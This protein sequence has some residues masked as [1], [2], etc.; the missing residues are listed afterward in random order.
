MRG[1]DHD[2][3]ASRM[4][5]A[6]RIYYNFGR[7]HSAP[8]GQTP[9]EKAAIDLGLGEGNKW[10]QLIRKSKATRKAEMP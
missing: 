8:N 2:A 7:P 4:M 3:S 10:E 6:N 1:L 5:D 9:T